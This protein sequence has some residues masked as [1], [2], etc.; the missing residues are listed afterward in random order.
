MMVVSPILFLS[1]LPYWKYTGKDPMI[2]QEPD[3]RIG[4]CCQ[5]YL[6]HRKKPAE[7]LIAMGKNVNNLRKYQLFCC[8]GDRWC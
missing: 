1:G 6:H 7:L 8:K 3:A 2:W 5:G 4:L